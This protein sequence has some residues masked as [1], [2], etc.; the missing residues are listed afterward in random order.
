MDDDQVDEMAG[1]VVRNYLDDGIP[2]L[3]IVEQT[4]DEYG[5]EGDVEEPTEE[6]H[7]AVAVAADRLITKLKDALD[8]L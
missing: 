6:D 5:W 7:K 4:N 1:Q 3:D 2:F 8:E